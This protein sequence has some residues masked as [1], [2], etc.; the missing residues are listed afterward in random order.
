ML[1][2]M[3]K[4][5]AKAELLTI[6]QMRDEVMDLKFSKKSK[7]IRKKIIGTTVHRRMYA[8]F[9]AARRAKEK[10]EGVKKPTA[11]TTAALEG[12]NRIGRSRERKALC[13]RTMETVEALEYF[14]AELFNFRRGHGLANSLFNGFKLYNGMTSG[15][16]PDVLRVRD[17]RYRQQFSS[18]LS[19]NI[20]SEIMK[21]V[22]AVT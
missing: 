12:Y 5:L 6:N 1:E 22:E 19:D 18:S 3:P 21:M 11:D 17:E 16:K 13:F 8:G 4:N 10:L 20:E 2:D 15:V 14:H 7:K 9:E